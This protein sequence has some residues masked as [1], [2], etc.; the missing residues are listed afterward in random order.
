M[1]ARTLIS[2]IRSAFLK[3][4]FCSHK[5]YKKEI[6]FVESDDGGDLNFS[7]PEGLCV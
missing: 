3:I 5:E 6:Q 7:A 2:V 4:L 1:L